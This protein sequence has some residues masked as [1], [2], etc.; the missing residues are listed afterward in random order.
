MQQASKQSKQQAQQHEATLIAKAR[1]FLNNYRRWAQTALLCDD[2]RVLSKVSDGARF[3]MQRHQASEEAQHCRKKADFVNTVVE[4]L[5]F[6]EYQVIHYH[7]IIGLSL[8][9]ALDS[10][11]MDRSTA[12]R[13]QRRALIHIAHL[14]E[15]L[16]RDEY[17][18]PTVA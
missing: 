7:Y 2:E 13:R 1:C 3:S 12:Y 11:R 16:Q 8:D 6:D 18:E 10:L 14:L 4:M 15:Y 9:R 5:P 17:G